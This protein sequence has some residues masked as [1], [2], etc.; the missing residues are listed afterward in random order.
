[1]RDG[2]RMWRKPPGILR[3][4]MFKMGRVGKNEAEGIDS[5]WLGTV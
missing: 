1:M 3:E 4:A 5:L 2:E